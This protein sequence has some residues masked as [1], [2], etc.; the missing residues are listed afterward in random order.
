MARMRGLE[1]R[2]AGWLARFVFRG[3]RRRVGQ[4]SDAW[5]IAA[6]RPG[7]LFGWALHELAY[8]RARGVDRRLRTLVQLK[9][10]M[11]IGCPV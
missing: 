2:E 7:L 3:V 11:L 4:V 8:E 5:R 6:H 9:A 1:D 10:A